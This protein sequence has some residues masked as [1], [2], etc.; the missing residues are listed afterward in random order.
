VYIEIQGDRA[1]VRDAD[2]CRSLD[3]R[4]PAGDRTQVDAALRA[5]GLGRWDGRA[6]AE[7]AVDALRAAAAGS[8]VGVDWHGRWD[9]MVDYAQSK[10]WVTDDGTRLRAHLIDVS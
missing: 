7:L 8:D 6:E 2:N 4:V 10:G 5:A 1:E 9:A 3:V